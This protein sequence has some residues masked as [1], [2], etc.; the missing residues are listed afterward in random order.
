MSNLTVDQAFSQALSLHQSG[1][2]SAAESIYREILAQHPNHADSLHLLGYI[3]FQTGHDQ[4]ALDL[5]QRAISL[6]PGFAVYHNNLGTIFEKLGRIDE[7]AAAYRTAL[8]LDPN[9]S[10]AL[11]NLGNILQNRGLLDEALPCYRAA[12]RHRPDHPLALYNLANLLKEQGQLDEAIAC[13]RRA[14]DLC[15]TRAPIHSNLLLALHYHPGYSAADLREE[16]RAWFERHAAPLRTSMKP[17]ANIREENRTLRIGYV[18]PDFFNHAVARFLLPLLQNHDRTRFEIFAYADVPNPDAVTA[19]LKA[20]V[21]VWHDIS[22]MDDAQ[23]AELIRRDQIDILVDLAAH[24]AR[25]RLLVFARKPA[26]IQVT[27]LAYCSTTGLD[28]ID[29]RLTDPFLDPDGTD[30]AN[31]VEESV[32]LPRTYWCYTAPDVPVALR[33]TPARETGPVNFGCLNNFC[34]VT[35]ATLRVWGRLLG[36]VLGSR[37]LLHA[38]AGSHRERVQDDLQALGID[39][40][41]VSFVGVQSFEQY[42]STYRQIDVALDPFPFTG[43]TTTCDALWMGVPVVSL[44]GPTAVSRGGV[45]L[46]T[47][48]GLPELVAQTEGDYVRIAS[49][50]AQDRLRL[51]ALRTSLRARLQASPIMDAAGFARDM[52][53]AFRRMWRRWCKS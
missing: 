45:S 17:H 13:Y 16:H 26:P 19:K 5:I 2:L 28:T 24:A 22:A 23:V 41:R 14:A 32:R 15:P 33:P 53:T 34:K 37:L 30:S 51:S 31:Y 21:N 40:A 20:Q 4:A 36:A 35:G 29:Y 50:L 12:L 3:G 46:L 6:Q 27:Y 18:S 1:R 8:Q 39:R 25:G 11:N 10:E 9:H 44:S 42:L 47:N 48:V 52:E 49:E 43:G 38:R 7:A